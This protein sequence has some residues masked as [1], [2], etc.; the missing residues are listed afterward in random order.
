M[1]EAN[2]PSIIHRFSYEEIELSHNKMI[3]FVI[4]IVNQ[5]LDILESVLQENFT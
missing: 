4:G 5:N 1:R 3:Q 2:K